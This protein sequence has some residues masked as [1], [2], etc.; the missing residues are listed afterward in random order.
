MEW[1]RKANNSWKA[2]E[3]FSADS[4][5]MIQQIENA[6]RINGK[7]FSEEALEAL[8]LGN[9]DG[10]INAIDWDSLSIPQSKI[11]N[12]LY[13]QAR[14]AGQ[15]TFRDSGIDAEL[16][17]DVIDQRAVEYALNASSTLIRNI[18]DEMRSSIRQTIA[19]ATNGG[20]TMRQAASRIKTDLPLLPR[21]VSAVDNF[22]IKQYE[23][24]FRAGMSDERAREKA[25][26]KALRYAQKLTRQRATMIARTEIVTSANQGRYLGWDEGVRNGYID[27]Q[28][29]KEWIAEPDACPECSPLDGKTVLW[30]EPFSSGDEMPPLHPNCRCSSAI[31][32][33]DYA[34]SIFINEPTQG[35]DYDQQTEEISPETIAEQPVADILAMSDEEAF[36][37]VSDGLADFNHPDV[38][39]V[40]EYAERDNNKITFAGHFE[41]KNGD[42]VGGFNRT[43]EKVDGKLAVFHE[44][45]RVEIPYKGRGISVEF[46]RVSE[47]FYK[48]LGIEKV[49]ID[50]GLKD[51][52]Y[53]WA[54]AGYQFKEKPESLIDSL[55][56][57]AKNVSENTSLWEPN[58]L[59]KEQAIALGGRI[60]NLADLLDNTPFNDPSYLTPLEI[61]NVQ[62]PDIYLTKFG[63]FILEKTEYKAYKDLN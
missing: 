58:K 16:L 2:P 48:S 29:V 50:A 57:K 15:S 28:S 59:T 36:N 5:R 41:N 60:E 17:F 30:N 27:S 24:F 13:E 14:V 40:T 52:A 43:F 35:A 20:L 47:N 19:T 42:N 1:I 56:R 53:T 34:D 7:E 63:R 33:P 25:E 38:S 8:R 49:F 61:A 54:K 37:A 32:P 55:R 46:G 51:G 3:N 12:V 10:F 26:A 11:Q 62:G 9:V 45:M 23:K 18:T 44:G 21:D 31:L 6:L 22:R 39:V 4:R